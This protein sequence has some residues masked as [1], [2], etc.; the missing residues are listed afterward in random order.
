MTLNTPDCTFDDR[1][2]LTKLMCSCEG[3]LQ[4]VV[5]NDGAAPLGVTHSPDVSHTQRVA[6]LMS[7]DVLLHGEEIENVEYVFDF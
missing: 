1:C 6:A 4:A 7:T 5:L 3:S 2:D